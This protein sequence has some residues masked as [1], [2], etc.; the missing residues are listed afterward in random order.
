MHLIDTNV[1][2]EVLLSQ[3][4]KGICKDF[5]DANVENL[6]ISDFSLHSIGVILFKN[7]KE[8]IFQKFANDIIPKVEIITLLKEAY[9]DL[10]DI[11]SNL[12]LDFDDA[13]QFNVAKEYDLKIVTMDRDFEK[14]KDRIEVIFL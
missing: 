13:Y 2:L 12:G 7:D 8:K 4:K 10:A 1:F 14:A 6:Y 11:R 5:L 9:K 3:E